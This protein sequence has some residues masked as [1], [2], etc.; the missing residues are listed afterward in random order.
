MAKPV[1][2]ILY[3][4][5]KT[6]ST[7]DMQEYD[8][9]KNL[10]VTPEEFWGETGKLKNKAEM[11]GILAYMYMMLKCCKD[12]NIKLTREYLNE[13]GKNIKLH[14]GVNTWFERINKYAESIGATVEHYLISSGIT[15]IVE[16]SD[17]AKYFK[18]IY[19]CT[20]LYGDDGEAIWPATAINFTLKTQFIYRISKGVLDIRD[21]YN[22]NKRTDDRRIPYRNFIYIGDGM[23]DIPSMK[24]VK[25]RGG[26]SIALYQ[27]NKQTIAELL[28]DERINYACK[29]DY[30]AN[31]TLE[32]I[33]KLMIETIVGL[34]TLETKE[35]KQL[36]MLQ[37]AIDEE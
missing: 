9:I 20:F 2:A 34:D 10:G 24:L 30:S 19:G 32:R 11:D 14:K 33:V 4:F 16:G 1:I 35:L 5:D 22:L 8:F 27:E 21:D 25:E 31:S 36:E 26:K 6:L 37:K 7:T 15:E 17:I 12:K 23:T 29:A 18:K 28:A 13:C 3:D